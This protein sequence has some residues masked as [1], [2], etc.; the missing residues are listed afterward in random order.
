MRIRN[1]LLALLGVLVIAGAL[2]FAPGGGIS[3][4]GTTPTPAPVLSVPPI[5]MLVSGVAQGAPDGYK[6]VARMIHGVVTY[7]SQPALIKDGQYLLKVGPPHSG[8]INGEV[9]FSLE[10][11]DANERISQSPGASHFNFTLTF[12]EIPVATLTPTP[13][14]VLPATYSGSITIAGVAVTPDMQLVIRVGDYTS[15]PAVILDNGD[16]INLVIITEDDSLIG[17]PVEFFLNGEPSTPPAIGVFEPGARPD[18]DLVFGSVPATETPIPTETS[19]PPT[20]TPVPPTATPV[21]TNTP[22]PPTATPVP[23]NTPVPPTASPSPT[24]TP[25]PPTAT[26]VPTNTPVPP[27]ATPIPV[28]AET[29]DEEENGGPCSAVAGRIG[30]GHATANMLMLFAP[31]LMLG[32]VKYARRR[33]D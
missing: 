7:E 27:T 25:V 12:P 6:I 13:V 11:V 3:A 23:T 33:K 1:S 31:L 14:P 4:Q 28:V 20:A 8:F 32:G 2:L 29:D 18:V 17:A 10:G 24:N 21:P 5:P 22:V 26:P 19:V 16:F 30:F 15:P 9:I